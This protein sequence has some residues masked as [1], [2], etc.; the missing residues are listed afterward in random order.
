MDSLCSL[1]VTGESSFVVTASLPPRGGVHTRRQGPKYLSDIWSILVV[2]WRDCG[3]NGNNFA[4]LA[5]H[6]SDNFLIQGGKALDVCLEVLEVLCR[7]G[8]VPEI[9]NEL[10]HGFR[11]RQPISFFGYGK[12]GIEPGKAG[13]EW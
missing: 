10:L 7:A 12:V 9:P 13:L 4:G 8:M 11:G 1:R 3:T 2:G 5:V 6:W